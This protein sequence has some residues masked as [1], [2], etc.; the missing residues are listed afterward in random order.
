[1]KPAFQKI[2]L[3]AFSILL[4]LFIAEILLRIFSTDQLYVWQPD[5]RH[6]FYPDT[7][8]IQGVDGEKHFSINKNGMR[9]EVFR[10]GNDNYLCIGGSTTE[11]LYLDDKETWWHILQQ[12]LNKRAKEKIIIGS[13]GKSG[14]TTRE[15][16]I[17]MK[18]FAP[19][20]KHLKGVIIMCGLNDLMIRLSRDS[21]FEKD[22]QFTKQAEDSLAS[23]IFLSN[24][25]HKACWRKLMIFKLFQRFYHHIKP[26]G[27][28]WLIQDD[29]GGSVKQWRQNRQQASVLIDS[30]P[31]L[32]NAL[33]EYSRNIHL[34]IDEARKQ[35][36][37]ITFINQAAMYRD[38]MNAYE[39]GLLWMGGIGNFQSEPGHP[40]YSSFALRKGLALYNQKLVE[41][42][43][44]R[45][46]KLVDIE[47]ALP[48]DTSAFYDDCHLNENG[49]KILG[50]YLS[51]A[52]AQ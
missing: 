17:Q 4:A 32:S 16:Y 3:A 18:Y 30:L 29:R 20:V 23:K 6:T 39:K 43:S 2:V 52:M 36:L 46:V 45:N 42:C 38:S 47:S 10:S 7:A 24:H 37:D 8:I 14:T 15:H 21:L 50:E 11:C 48:R 5:L 26:G 28:K 51:G 19:K 40:Y 49:A 34:F 9:G 25:K 44:M 41:V 35:N 13:I 1:M 27:V 31:D 12:E 22:F 33:E